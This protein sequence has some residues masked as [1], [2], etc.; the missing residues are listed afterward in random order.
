MGAVLIGRIK[1]LEALCLL[2]VALAS[3]QGVSS[4]S[5]AVKANRSMTGEVSENSD[6]RSFAIEA[7]EQKNVTWGLRK[8]DGSVTEVNG[9]FLEMSSGVG[10]ELK[11]CKTCVFVLERIKKG[12]NMILPAIC[13]EIYEKYPKDYGTCHQVLNA[14]TVNGG[15]IRYWLFEGCYKYEIYQA[16]EWIKPCPS[17]VMCSALKML[18]DKE[19]CKPMKMEDPF[20]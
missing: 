4:R 10:E 9:S 19:F 13:S 3:I 11:E 2:A 20:K 16:K 14:L 6:S 8:S 15:N 18:D 1:P 12:T 5:G 17:H 7:T